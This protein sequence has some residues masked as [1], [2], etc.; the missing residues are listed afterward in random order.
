M[1][2]NRLRESE[3]STTSPLLIGICFPFPHTYTVYSWMMYCICKEGLEHWRQ[4][5]PPPHHLWLPKLKRV[6][7]AV[8]CP[9]AVLAA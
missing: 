9:S 2:F 7:R 4:Q 8:R 1:S 3:F 5:Q 6:W